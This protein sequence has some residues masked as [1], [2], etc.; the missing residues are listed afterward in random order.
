MPSRT[1]AVV[2]SIAALSVAATPTF[3]LA[4]SKPHPSSTRVDRSRDAAGVRHVDVSRDTS[5]DPS[6]DR[7]VDP[8][9]F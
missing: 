8:R 5:R 7:S 6:V 4:A 3:A 9:D 2:A 1:I